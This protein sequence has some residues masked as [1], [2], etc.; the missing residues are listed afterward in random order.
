[1]KTMHQN[2]AQAYAKL[3]GDNP[4]DIPWI[5]WLLENPESPIA[6]GGSISLRNHDYMHVLLEKG[7]SPEDEAFVIG[8]TMGNDSRTRFWDYWI[9]KFAA[10]FLYPGVY[11][12]TQ[13]HLQRFDE[14][15]ALGRSL[16][17]RDLNRFDFCRV[18]NV[19]VRVLQTVFGIYW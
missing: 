19:P 13:E 6:L 1:M 10:R 4:W 12:F 5:I 11:R 3:G 16:P 2:L 14:G 18:E 17:V 15:V 9:F 7:F 8:V